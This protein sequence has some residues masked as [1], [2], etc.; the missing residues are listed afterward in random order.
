MFDK[1][2]YPTPTEIIQ[3]MLQPYFQKSPRWDTSEL[4]LSGKTILEPSAGKGDILLYIEEQLGNYRKPD[5]IYCIEKHPD[6]QAVLREK[7]F[8]LIEDDF[9]TF[10][11]P[12]LFDLIIMNPPFDKG[13]THLLKAWDLLQTGEIICLLNAKTYHNPYSQERQQLKDIIDAHGTIETLDDCFSDA[14]RTTNVSVILVRL[15]KESKSTFDFQ[16]DA[17]EMET[18]LEFP[19]DLEQNQV[20]V[21]DILLTYEHRYQASVAAFREIQ[22]AIQKFQYYTDGVFLDSYHL[23]DYLKLAKEKSINPFIRRFNATCWGKVLAESKFESFLTTNVRRSFSEKFSHQT[24]LAFTKA[25]MITL[26]EILW[27]NKADILESCI[28]DVFDIMT[29]YHHENRAQIEG[30][31]TNDAW[32]VNRKVILP[33]YISYG[34]YYS[35][36]DLKKYGAEFRVSKHSQLLDIDRCMSYINA[37]RTEHTLTITEA[38]KR[39]F[40]FL[41]SVRTGE[42]FDKKCSSTYFDIKFFKKGTLHLTFRDEYLWREFNYRAAK[43]KGFP[44]PEKMHKT[45]A[46]DEA[47]HPAP[48]LFPSII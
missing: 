1:N 6:L 45:A 4:N 30:W 38:L 3:K 43:Y 41:G 32:R 48:S 34:S 18:P 47:N 35:A 42:S 33:Y 36:E 23:S 11:S 27:Q 28:E 29:M 37:K 7:D 44:L 13:A 19:D 24:K 12:Y 21:L 22:Q 17:F 10:E 15:T 31:K 26:F 2:F 14:E 8:D 9:L 16:D 40:S 20:Q 5:A 25:N 46:P 39:H